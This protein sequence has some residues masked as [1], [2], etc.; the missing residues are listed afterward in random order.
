MKTAASRFRDRPQAK[1]RQDLDDIAVLQRLRIG[2]GGDS[3]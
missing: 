1:R 2:V 3:A